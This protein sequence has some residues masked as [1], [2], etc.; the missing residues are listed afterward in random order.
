LV[1]AV[2]VPMSIGIDDHNN[3]EP[4]LP[5]TIAS[6]EWYEKETGEIKDVSE[7]RT[8]VDDDGASDMSISSRHNTDHHSLEPAFTYSV[9]KQQPM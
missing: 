7:G 9:S 8:I 1:E 2:I 5:S 4:L 3:L 6:T